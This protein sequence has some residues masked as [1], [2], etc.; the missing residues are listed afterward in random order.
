MYG[1][2]I[3][4]AVLGITAFGYFTLKLEPGTINNMAFYTLIL[5]QLLNLFNI[6]K[7]E[8]PFI[9]NEVTTNLWV[10]SAIALCIFLTFLAA[11]IPVVAEALT[12]NHL[13]L[14]QYMYIVLFAFGSLLMA[15]IIK[16]IGNF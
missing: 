6:P 1:L 14:D 9:K 12:I 15:Q 16:R 2:S 7:S 4:A 8:G 11:T 5:A 13:T 3:S 10:W